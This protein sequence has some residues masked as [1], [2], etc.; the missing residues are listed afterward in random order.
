MA[1]PRCVACI[2]P[3]VTAAVAWAQCPE[4][5]TP[6][7]PSDDG[8]RDYP[9]ALSVWDRD[10]AGAAPPLLAIGGTFT[11]AGDLNARSIVA[12]DTAAGQWLRL[13][14]LEGTVDHLLGVAGG[15]LVASGNL[16][17]GALNCRVASFDGTTWTALART[18]EAEVDPHV[19]ALAVL[20]GGSL[21]IGGWFTAI[22]SVPARNI[23]LW[24]GS[25]WTPIGPGSNGGI[26]ALKVRANGHLIVGGFFTSIGGVAA[27]NIARWDGATWYGLGSG[28]PGPVNAISLLPQGHIATTNSYEV[29]RWDGASWTRLGEAFHRRETEWD[30]PVLALHTGP[31]GELIAAG[32]FDAC[33][34]APLPSIAR[35]TG[36]AWVP[37]GPPPGPNQPLY[38]IDALCT[39]PTGEIVAAGRF[40][41]IGGINASRLAV[42]R[43][44]GWTPIGRRL[45]RSVLCAEELPGGDLIVGGTFSHAAGVPVSHIAVQH[46]STFLPIGGGTDDDVWLLKRLSNGDIIAAG[47]FNSAGGLPAQ[48]I[49]RWD[50]SSWRPLGSGIS[51]RISAI[52]ELP[53]GDI[54]V[55][56]AFEQAGGRQVNNIARWNGAEWLALGGGVSGSG[57]PE[58][59]ALQHMP[60]GTL[61][62]AGSF[63]YAEGVPVGHVARWNGSTWTPVGL[64]FNQAVYKFVMSASGDL[65]ASGSFTASGPLAI[66]HFAHWNGTGWWP[67]EGVTVPSDTTLDLVADADGDLLVSG[68]FRIG[69]GPLADGVARNGAQ[70]WAR[71][72]GLDGHANFLAAL[73]SGD[74]LLTGSFDYAGGLFSPGQ[75]RLTR[76][77]ACYS[78]C[79]CSSTAPTLNALDFNCFLNHFAAGHPYA[80]CDHSTATPAL[81]VLD[82]N[83]FLNA[84]T[85]GCP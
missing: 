29:W 11:S 62:A 41:T 71:L 63:L 76:A 22:D 7:I 66:N 33:G 79:D 38:P 69:S 43:A 12:W 48:H 5:W 83:C 54:A 42:L 78:N 40:W 21:V 64:G 14:N 81:N 70:G 57:Y 1:V 73:P 23:A 8:V 60:D 67:V 47:W 59:R 31:A 9:R 35:W 74:V 16:R 19:D 58:V 77:P 82:F 2:A 55:G 18:L 68:W 27:S 84:F 37:L 32:N 34:E 30:P 26:G 50:G 85:A 56:G 20:P 3:L 51:G 53:G 28:P 13:G 4:R 45:N 72:V 52:E 36:D 6:W 39:M 17:I 75:T 65:F 46:G 15:S 25:A 61:I 80:N 44:S 10:G 24:N 49:A